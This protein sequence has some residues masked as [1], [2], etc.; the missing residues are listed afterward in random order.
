MTE[1]VVQPRYRWVI[2]AAAALM[3]ALAMGQLVSGLSVFFLPLEREFGWPRGDIALIN[4]AGLIG[5]AA[6]GILL[7]RLTDRAGIRPVCIAGAVVLGLCVAAAS[8]AEALWQF[9]L[10]FLL[11][12][13]F[14]GAAFFAP[15]L[16][17]TGN[18]FATG[19]GLALGIVS[20]GQALGQ[21]AIPLVGALAIEALGWRGAF[22]A[23]G[24]AT[25]ALL[26]PLSLLV[27]DPPRRA[28]P[29]QGSASAGMHSVLPHR[30]V[31]VMLSAA[32]LCCCTLMSVPLMH[33]VPLMQGCGIAAT[34]AGGVMF[35]ML[36][37]GILGRLCF[38][39]LADM[40]GAIP[41]YMTASFW[42]TAMVFGFTQFEGLEA[43][44]L[45]GLLYG[46][47]YAGVMTGVLTT[48]TALTPPH[49]R[50]GAMG[51]VTAFAFL[52]HGVGGYAGGWLFDLTGGYAIAFGT[53]AAA[54]IVN[55][56]IIA[57]LLFGI[58][59]ARG[60]QPA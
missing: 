40:I 13:A 2:A 53:A 35:A 19:A 7:G 1:A 42:Q 8:Q 58:R 31:L 12:G 37:T 51:I 49:R 36:A 28:G 18:W 6:G 29:A 34:D 26:L 38:G 10:L 39:R 45:Y 55:L 59:R 22:A 30:L 5:L 16:A 52:G 9:Y 43:F 17:L 11:G 33:L 25:L 3:L 47:G 4:T 14:G 56:A 60:A 41:A 24:L 44:Y 21:G 46:F 48:T 23:L 15:V 50:A 32:V 57:L 27:R 20:A 54:G